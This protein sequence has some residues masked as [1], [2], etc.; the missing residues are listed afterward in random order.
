MDLEFK[1]TAC[2]DSQTL[3]KA[4]SIQ[5]HSMFQALQLRSSFSGE[6]GAQIREVVHLRLRA[7]PV[8][9]KPVFKRRAEGE[10]GEADFSQTAGDAE[11]E[12]VQ[13]RHGRTL[14]T[15]TRLRTADSSPHEVM[16]GPEL[17]PRAIWSF[18]AEA[19]VLAVPC[20]ACS[21]CCSKSLRTA[22]SSVVRIAA[23]AIAAIAQQ[24]FVERP[25]PRLLCSAL[26]MVIKTDLCN[27][28]ECLG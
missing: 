1:Q 27:Y 15:F 2:C 17:Q 21:A 20:S 28:T 9:T 22:C 14:G 6:E 3:H 16:L 7:L 4:W 10:A 8:P 25:S 12:H 18:K 5:T 11:E 23:A 19:C 26:A 13:K 24:L